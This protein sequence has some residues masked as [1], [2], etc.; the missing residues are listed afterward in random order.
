MHAA[1]SPDGSHLVFALSA[2][3]NADIWV[4]N[5][6]GSELRQ[7]T[8]DPAADAW[9]VWSPDGRSIMFASLRDGAW[10]TRR[11]PASGRIP[12]RNSSTD[13]L[14]RRLD[15]QARR[16]RHLAGQQ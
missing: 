11:I 15:P 5:V 7:L 12:R 6:D 9:P 16:V 4:Q 13:S 1:V 3:G 8:N 10:E 14:P 2:T